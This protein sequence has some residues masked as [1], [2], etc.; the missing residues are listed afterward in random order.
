MTSEVSLVEELGR[1]DGVAQA[2][3]VRRREVSAREMVEAAI[4]RIEAGN[5][6]I[7]AV[8]HRRF[9]QALDE[10]DRVAPESGAPF[11]G[12][13][14]LLKDGGCEQAGVAQTQ[15]N[16]ALKEIHRTPEADSPLGR[17][18]RD[19]GLLTVGVTNMPEF[20]QLG[21]TQPLAFGPTRN[22]WCPDRSASGSSGG[23][24]AAVAAGLVPIAQGGDSAG[25]I[26]QPAA[27]CGVFALK[28]SRGRVPRAIGTIDDIW[29]S[30]LVITRTVRDTAAVLDAV[31]GSLPGDP[32]G[33]GRLDVP[34]VDAMRSPRRG[35][36]I[37]VLAE[38]PAGLAVGA[39]CAHAVQEVVR[40]LE[41]AGHHVEASFPS[42]MLESIPEWVD[43]IVH[44]DIFAGV[45]QRLEN[46][47]GRTVREDDVEPYTWYRFS[48]SRPVSATDLRA[49][50]GWHL[51]RS[52]RLQEWW[53]SGFDLLITPVS[54]ELPDRLCDLA[55]ESPEQMARTERRHAAFLE[56]FNASGQ[57]AIS[58]PVRW[59]DD[60]IPVGV[61]I[62]AAKGQDQLLLQVAA[63]LEEAIDWPAKL[64]AQR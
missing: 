7:N 9:E 52:A 51:R 43:R 26:R 17:R 2:G 20:G 1:L 27:W 36:R 60:G 37:G 31:N 56:P 63:Q 35:L 59:T 13:P 19:S 62:A 44:D 4:D 40:H 12:V 48:N 29:S 5:P 61:Q 15:G 28:T 45:V 21:D 39:E 23:A 41:D 64:P 3:L 30:R 10:A 34:S 57:P 11:A 58:V 38:G 49:A 16:V 53:E 54:N 6:A 47:V 24:G 25:S 8:V 32:Y 33:L 42:A 18:F 46:I 14:F 55:S 22:P 50:L